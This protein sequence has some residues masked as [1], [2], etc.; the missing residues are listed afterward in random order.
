MNLSPEAL[1][2]WMNA[3]PPEAIWPLMLLLCFGSVLVL[4]R[5][6]GA[7]GLY[8]YIAVAVIGANIQVLKA[9]KFALYPDP[10][11]LG[12]ILFASTYLATDILA[13]QF[14]KQA[15]Q[16]GVWLGFVA[17]LLFTLLMILN[18]GYAP[19]TPA[20]AGEAMAWALPYHTHMVNLFTPQLT[21]FAAGMLAYLISQH[22]DVWLYEWLRAR[23]SQHLWLRN[24]GSTAVSA[25]IDNTVFSILAWIVFAAEPLPFSTVFFTYILGTYWLRL[26]VAVLDTPFIYLARHWSYQER[27]YSY[28]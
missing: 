23:F 18:L 12:T 21:F 7:A 9:V 2:T 3:W 25:L 20:Q 19:L 24:N 11:A 6:F 4:H 22:H 17:F 15:A 13:E 5:L 8:V 28:A 27:K 26:A 16:R 1:I 14:G 10:V